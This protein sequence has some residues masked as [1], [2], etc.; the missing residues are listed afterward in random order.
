MSTNRG[1]YDF[2]RL[3]E[4]DKGKEYCRRFAEAI[5]NRS[6]GE[7]YSNRFAVLSEC[8][9]FFQEGTSGDL[10]GYLQ[11]AEDGTELPVPWLTLNTLQTKINLLLGEHEERGYDIKVQ[12]LN[13]EAI[14][15]K[16]EAKE[17]LRVRRRL[18][19][20]VEEMAAQTGM[21]LENPEDPIPQTEAELNELFDLTYKDKVEIIIQSALKFLAKI[22]NW[23]EE[24]KALF[25]DVLIA[26]RAIVKNEIVRGVPRSRR[27]DPLMFIYD[28]DCKMDSLEDSTY[29]GEIEYLP[30]ASASERYGLS[31]EEIKEVYGAYQNY[32]NMGSGA[33]YNPEY[34]G[35]G[36]SAGNAVKW[37][38]EID[39]QLR[40]LVG[41]T[42]WRDYKDYTYKQEEDRYGTEHLQEVSKIRKRDESKIKTKKIEVW[43]QATIIGGLVMRE[44]GECPNQP[45][46]PSALE[47]T[48]PA[49]KVWI[50]NFAI[51]RGVSMVEQLAHLQLMKDIAMYNMNLVLTTSTGGK[52]LIYD[53]AMTPEG[54]TPEQM[55]KYMKVHKV[56]F[57]NS[58]ESQLM[59]GNMNLFK[60][61]DLALSESIAQYM[62]IMQFYDSE[63]D[64]ISG[65]SPER[66][67]IAP[68]A[69]QSATA[70]QA[71]MLGSNL[72]TAPIFK[73]FERFCSRV[74]NHQAGL[75]QIVFPKSPEVFA[76]IIGDTGVDFLRDNI[77]IELD[78][79][80][81]FVE[82]MPPDY[83]TRQKLEQLIMMAT[84]SD[85][86]LLDDVIPIMME[87]DTQVALRRFQHVRKIRKVYMM[88]QQQAQAEQENMTQQ[89]LAALEADTADRQ[90][91]GQLENTKL[92]NEGS[93][94]RTLASSRTH[95]A[96]SKVDGIYELEKEKMKPKPAPP[97]SKDKK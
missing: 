34:H 62:G 71:V 61:V 1:T 16:L 58:K 87:P 90:I 17:E 25:R 49:Y 79:V 95:L 89:R 28:L 45:R 46:K 2:P 33:P 51:G 29:F 21:D 65:V 56:A 50:P 48:E 93:L 15:R 23:D 42:T 53:L 81:V 86:E 10:T 72:V 78:E 47:K 20:L 8:Y 83:I 27:V 70:T 38:K 73:G 77:E 30:L 97:T 22:N 36:V 35:F 64:K 91:Q 19:P 9:K 11:K 55:L 92:K 60:E 18:Q 43:R 26:G 14:S 59:P 94:E 40:V 3:D 75:V 66:Q 67:G 68:P 96:K 52:M 88:A 41:R 39:G 24:R 76:P 85:P 69:S 80:G 32:L 7:D 4:K 6:L 82:S 31:N 63:M 37:F 57:V 13:K 54:W 84:Q 44:W 74:L 5:L 12:A